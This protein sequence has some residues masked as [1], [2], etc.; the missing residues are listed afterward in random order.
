MEPQDLIKGLSKLVRGDDYKEG[1][2]ITEARIIE[3]LDALI[4]SDDLAL[5][6]IIPIFMALSAQSG[7][8]M[9]ISPLLEKYGPETPQGETLEKFFLI[10]LDLLQSEGTPVPA[11]AEERAEVLTK[12]WGDWIGSGDLELG[13]GISLSKDRLRH[14][15]REYAR[16]APQPQGVQPDETARP[17]TSM[18]PQLHPH[19]SILFSPK[20]VELIIKRLKGDQFS[21][22]DREYYSRVVKKKLQALADESVQEIASTLTSR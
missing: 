3:V 11:D 12:K 19:L 4:S 20:Q 6:E 13:G 2:Q 5:M 7:F 17:L 15:F 10:A 16:T 1:D 8:S 14:V 9:D 22:T 18:P 21:K